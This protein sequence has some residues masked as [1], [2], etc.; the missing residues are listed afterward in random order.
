MCPIQCNDLLY[1][2]EQNGL[3]LDEN[4]RE[5]KKQAQSYN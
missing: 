3:F 5:K 1:L 2:S 4:R